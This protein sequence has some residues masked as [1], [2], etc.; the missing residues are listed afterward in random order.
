MAA[1]FRQE[2]HADPRLDCAGEMNFHLTRQIK[3][4][5]NIDDP[6]KQ[7]SA[8]P[9][10]VYE[11]IAISGGTHVQEATNEL[12]TGALFFGMRSCEYS[13]VPTRDE[14]VT[15]L[16]QL[17]DL[18]FYDVENKQL[19]QQD[20][21]LHR[22]AHTLTITFKNQKNR[23]KQQVIPITKSNNKLCPVKIWAQIVKRLWSYVDTTMQTDVNVVRIPRC[24]ETFVVTKR[25][26]ETKL[27]SA[28]LA[29][30]EDSL[31]VKAID[32]GCHSIRA[33]FATILQLS[34]E[35]ETKIQQHGRW[36]SDCYKTYMR[37]NVSKGGDTI[38]TSLSSTT[39]NFFTFQAKAQHSQRSTMVPAEGPRRARSNPKVK[40]PRFKLG[41]LFT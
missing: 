40:T 30:G 29:L 7:R 13:Q 8:L 18:H 28:V 25:N 36:Q 16:L 4:Y 15:K 23:K 24:A 5:K 20:K 35:K 6:V 22:T 14:Q 19:D 2:G 32:T 27:K 33:T 12:I 1:A 31:G 10:R 34:A 3:H 39:G 41:P 37:R 17:E 26:V 21:F 9:I 11:F 38:S